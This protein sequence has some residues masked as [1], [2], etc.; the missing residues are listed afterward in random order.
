[1]P[2]TPDPRRRYRLLAPLIQAGA[3]HAAGSTVPLRPDQA[4]RL[5]EQ[6][7]VDIEAPAKPGRARKL[8]G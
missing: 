1:M 8:E 7:V 4:A 5:A 2:D 3:E 6:G